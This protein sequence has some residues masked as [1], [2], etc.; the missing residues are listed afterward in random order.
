MFHVCLT[1]PDLQFRI[2]IDPFCL[3]VTI[4]VLC[5]VMIISGS[6]IILFLTTEQTHIPCI[7]ENNH[8]PF[9]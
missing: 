6:D 4:L 7:D 5:T 3:L 9:Q 1:L 8:V 2:M